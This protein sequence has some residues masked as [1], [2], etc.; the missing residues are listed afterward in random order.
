[1]Y[2]VDWTRQAK[3][4]YDIAKKNGFARKLSEIFSVVE[5]DPYEDT[6]GHHYEALLDNLKGIHTRRLNIHNRFVYEIL[7]NT[8]KR[9]DEYGIEYEGIVN[10]LIMWGHFP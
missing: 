2:D 10:V 6:P 4:D 8:E 9:K 5:R 3:K 1:M 7:P